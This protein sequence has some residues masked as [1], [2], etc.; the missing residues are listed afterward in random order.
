MIFLLSDGREIEVFRQTC[1]YQ[2]KLD[3]K[4]TPSVDWNINPIEIV[5]E[6]KKGM[7][8]ICND[9]GNGYSFQDGKWVYDV[10]T[11]DELI[12]ISSV[13]SILRPGEWEKPPEYQIPKD[14]LEKE[15]FKI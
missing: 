4:P 6:K 1:G 3:W 14:E 7:F 12:P 13:V 11:I 15:L 10:S 2:Y 5:R 8:A 9:T